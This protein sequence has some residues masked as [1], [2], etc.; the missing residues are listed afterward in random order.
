MDRSRHRQSVASSSR[1]TPGADG[2]T[3]GADRQSDTWRRQS[4]TWR[5]RSD[6]WRRQTDRAETDRPVDHAT[7]HCEKRPV[8]QLFLCLSRAGLGKMI[9]V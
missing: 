1:S 2:A 6:T 9:T 7:Y 4:D 8:S 5:R 3:R